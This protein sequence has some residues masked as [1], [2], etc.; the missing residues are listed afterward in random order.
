MVSGLR[1][2]GVQA[3]THRCTALRC[4]DRCLDHLGKV[5]GLVVTQE[6]TDMVDGVPFFD[7]EFCQFFNP[8]SSI[9]SL[10][11]AGC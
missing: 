8:R 11:P 1:V 7:G 6:C 2:G 3:A 4:R 5:E 10:A 9:P